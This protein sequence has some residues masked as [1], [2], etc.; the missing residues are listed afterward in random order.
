M[1]STTP[2]TSWPDP[3]LHLARRLVGEGDGEDLVRA[4]PAGVAAGGRCGWSAPGS[5]RCRRRPAPAPGRR[6]P[7]PPRAGRGSARRGRAP[8]RA[9]RRARRQRARRGLEGFRLVVD[10]VLIRGQGNRP[11][12]EWEA[13]VR[14][15]VR[16]LRAGILRCA[17]SG[18]RPR[19]LPRQIPTVPTA[20]AQAPAAGFPQLRSSVADGPRHIRSETYAH[21][22][23]RCR[24]EAARRA[25]SRLAAPRPSSAWRRPTARR[26]DG[27]GWRRC[28]TTCLPTSG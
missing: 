28:P 7:R 18:R 11:A 20:A 21:D 6:A 8:G 14:R 4:R 16:R 27:S 15:C 3:R 2:P 17:T 9:G 24:R 22:F 5:C 12:R 23:T 26:R 10:P 19:R 25:P 1:P 13:R